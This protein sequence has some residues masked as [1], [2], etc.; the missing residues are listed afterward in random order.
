MSITAEAF[1]ANRLR[2]QPIQDSVAQALLAGDTS[3]V[4]A[5]EGWPHGNTM[6]GLQMATS[7]GQPFWLVLLEGAVVGDSERSARRTRRARFRSAAD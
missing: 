5:A 4:N 3:V 1:R 2:F 7:T 6:L